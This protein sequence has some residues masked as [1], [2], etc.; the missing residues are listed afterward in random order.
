MLAGSLVERRRHCWLGLQACAHLS[1]EKLALRKPGG[2][3]SVTGHR[4]PSESHQQTAVRSE[5]VAADT[6]LAAAA[7]AMRCII[8][9]PIQ[10]T[11]NLRV[12]ATIFFAF[13][14]QHLGT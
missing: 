14:R 13:V 1:P 2:S 9:G 7:P 8:F 5:V 10:Q 11:E 3:L 6:A 12:P 4:F